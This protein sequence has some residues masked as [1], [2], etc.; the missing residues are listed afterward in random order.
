MPKNI[1]YGIFG[2][3]KIVQNDDGS[4]DLPVMIQESGLYVGIP[5]AEL[6]INH[7][8]PYDEPEFN[9][10]YVAELNRKTDLPFYLATA[11]IKI[12]SPLIKVT[13]ETNDAEGI[14]R[15]K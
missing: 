14:E 5:P 13:D 4:Y 10:Q 15:L 11:R 6:R 8:M 3:G 12:I 7:V 1:A 2:L 9:K